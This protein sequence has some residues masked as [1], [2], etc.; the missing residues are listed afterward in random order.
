LV[1]L[2]VSVAIFIFMTALLVAK[3]GNFNSSVLLTD[4]AYDVALTVR[5]AQTYGLGVTGTNSI[6][7]YPYGVDFS[8]SN[9]TVLTLYSDTDSNFYYSSVDVP[10]STYTLTRGAVVKDLCLDTVIPTSQR[11]GTDST[12]VDVPAL[13][14]SFKRPDPTAHICAGADCSYTYAQIT[15][16]GTDGSE[17]LVTVQQNGEISV[18]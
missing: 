13:D 1:E 4:I 14:I 16:Q 12:S 3:Y 17:R 10:V 9:G 15:I 7:T 5:T 6:F 18:E 11:C 8:T 2:L